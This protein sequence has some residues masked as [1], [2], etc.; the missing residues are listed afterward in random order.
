MTKVRHITMLV[1]G[2]L[3][4]VAGVLALVLPGPGLLM[5]FSGLAILSQ[6]YAWAESGSGRSRSAP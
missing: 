3:L 1:L 6:H 4:V 5:V 2:W